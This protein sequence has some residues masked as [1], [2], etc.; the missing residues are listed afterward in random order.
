MHPSLDLEAHIF[1]DFQLS[2]AKK[3]WE[4]ERAAWR[5]V[6]FMNLIRNVTLAVGCLDA[7]MSNVPL[8]DD[9][10]MFDE[11]IPSPNR[12]LPCVEF[13]EEH[14]RLVSSL[15]KLFD[16]QRNLELRVGVQVQRSVLGSSPSGPGRYVDQGVPE[17]SVH[18]PEG[19][20]TGLEKSTTGQDLRAQEA[21]IAISLESVK[22]DIKKLWDDPIVKEILARRRVRLEEM[23]GL[24]VPLCPNWRRLMLIDLVVVSLC[25]RTG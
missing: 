2:Y 13:T 10:E 8:V 12:G 22:D 21:D 16:I 24:Y 11:G 6:I 5:P 17:S 18:S 25:M 7:E 15:A 14:R 9:D 3:E 4:E 20:E 23:P 1:V 19:S